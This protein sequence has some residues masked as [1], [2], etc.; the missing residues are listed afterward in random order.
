MRLSDSSEAVPET[1]API[2]DTTTDKDAEASSIRVAGQECHQDHGLVGGDDARKRRCDHDTATSSN[3]IPRKMYSEGE[4]D[5]RTRHNAP[6]DDA[7]TTRA[8]DTSNLSAEASF[9]FGEGRTYSAGSQ[10]SQDDSNAYCPGV[11]L[12]LDEVS[13]INSA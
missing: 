13:S 1:G 2:I 10:A 11:R 4:S 8:E 3:K 6:A 12:K 9:D 5:T 7:G